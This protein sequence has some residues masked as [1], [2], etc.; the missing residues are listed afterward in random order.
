MLRATSRATSRTAGLSSRQLLHSVS[1]SSSSSP[2]YY[3]S[4]SSI[5]ADPQS[6]RQYSIRSFMRGT[7]RI[8]A[9]VAASSLLLAGGYWYGPAIKS[10]IA[11]DTPFSTS[12]RLATDQEGQRITLMSVEQVSSRLRDLEESYFL[13]RGKG[14]LR[15]DVAQLPSNAPIEDDRSEKIV[16]VPLQEGV[17]DWM[18]WGV[19]DG[20][21]GWTTSAK[22]RDELITSVLS[23][24]DQVYIK[25]T[26]DESVRIMPAPEIIDKAIED[27]FVKLDDDIVNQSVQ[28]FLANPSKPGAAE[29]IGPAL[30]GSCGLLAF[31]DSFSQDLRVAVTGDSRAVLGSL[32]ENGSWTATALSIDQTGSNE[33]EAKRMQLEHPG[34]EERVIRR[35]RVLGSLEPTRAFGDARYKWSKAIQDRIATNFAPQELK[36]P[37]YV[38]ARP[39]ITTTKIHPE[40][41]D[42]MVIASDGLYELLSNEEI[43]G[44]VVEWLAAKEPLYL[45][46]H[47]S[48]NKTL[49][50]RVFGSSG[51]SG[52]SNNVTASSEEEGTNIRADNVKG[53]VTVKD[54]T[55]NKEAQK[56]TIRR[57][58]GAPA[59]HFTVEDDNVSTHLI[60]NALGGG[61]L[62]QLSVL[63]SIPSPISRNYRDDLTVTVVFFGESKEEATGKVRVNDKA[64]R[65]SLKTH[66]K[67]KM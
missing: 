31:Y 43:V 38:T 27:G 30:S 40:K 39:I 65:N 56:Q 26:E 12:A 42:F 32:D 48:S 17:S 34:E 51:S 7:N 24:L 2:S 53:S 1:S 6:C 20:H 55:P 5:L 10:K 52:S 46:S 19:F 16:Q 49:W 54:T 58:P 21:S 4:G 47:N 23:E 67:A 11:L 61:D 15:Y 28:K 44:L 64:T 9:A 41:G 33:A 3:N 66:V 45:T 36:T 35:G 60:R 13:D 14:V 25:D 18:F 8:S 57:R 22:L 62:E 29:V 37:P 50:N 63:V 59:P